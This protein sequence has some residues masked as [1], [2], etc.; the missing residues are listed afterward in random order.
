MTLGLLYYYFVKYRRSWIK[1]QFL[2]F[3]S[4]SLIERVKNRNHIRDGYIVSLTSMNTRIDKLHY[5]ILS[6]INGEWLPEAVVL[7]L[8]S[9]EMEIFQQKTLKV[10]WYNE[11][12]NLNFL[13]LKE[14]EDV[15]SYKKIVFT[16]KAFPNHHIIICDDDILYPKQW[17][18]SIISSKQNIP[19]KT[20]VAHRVHRID[21]DLQNHKI[22]SYKQWEFN[23]QILGPSNF[24]FPT[25]VGGVLYPPGSLTDLASNKDLFMSLCPNAD[26]IWFWLCALNNGYSIAN[27]TLSFSEELFLEIPNSQIRSLHSTNVL[28]NKNDEQLE[29]SLNFFE[30]ITNDFKKVIWEKN[31]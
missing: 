9:S 23:S 15:K 6:I 25:G 20:I 18:K 3:S 24:L 19:N 16:L 21:Y 12:I 10:D 1:M 7:N 28:E 13:I 29:N 30:G 2:R 31:M 14:V 4:K 5:V 26:D 17:L 8:S 22:K 27:T 11:L